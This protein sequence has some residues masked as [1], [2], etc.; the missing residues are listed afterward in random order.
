[1]I[2]VWF[3]MA[4]GRKCMKSKKKMTKP[5]MKKFRAMLLEIK[6]KMASKSLY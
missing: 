3:L 6:I 1:M 4:F 5:D 2:T